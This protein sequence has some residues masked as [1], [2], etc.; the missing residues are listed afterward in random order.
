MDQQCHPDG[1]WNKKTCHLPRVR[2]VILILLPRVLIW[3]A[4]ASPLA[5][6]REPEDEGSGYLFIYLTHQEA[7]CYGHP[8][9]V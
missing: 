5:P 9:V 7:S 6:S 3:R 1:G 4:T 8:D 2:S